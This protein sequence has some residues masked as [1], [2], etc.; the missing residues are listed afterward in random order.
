LDE[1][2]PLVVGGTLNSGSAFVMRAT[3]VGADASLSQ[4][5][6]LVENAQLA[7]AGG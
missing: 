6:K 5:V 7:K 3:R 2:Q 1:C 4:I